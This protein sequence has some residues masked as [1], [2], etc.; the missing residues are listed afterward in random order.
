MNHVYA[1]HLL[2]PAKSAG[3]YNDEEESVSV[4]QRPQAHFEQDKAKFEW[5]GAQLLSE[6]TCLS[7]M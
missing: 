6:Q 1:L 3:E 5:R 7:Q 2:S 4:L